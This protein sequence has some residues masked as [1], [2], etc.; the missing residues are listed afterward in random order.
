MATAACPADF[1]V[2]F[3]KIPDPVPAPKYFDP[4][5]YQGVVKP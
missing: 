5:I 4:S 3:A 2:D 1:F